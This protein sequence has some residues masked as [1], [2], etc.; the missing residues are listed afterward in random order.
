MQS[1]IPGNKVLCA[2]VQNTVLYTVQCLTDTLDR[3]M[4][5][6]ALAGVVA[7]LAL[8]LQL[9]PSGCCLEF[10]WKMLLI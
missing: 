3:W 4:L 6:R 10:L 7:H 2:R 9:C 8:G 1:F 5:S